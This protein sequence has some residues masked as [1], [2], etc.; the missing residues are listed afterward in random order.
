M[1]SDYEF[2]QTDTTALVNALIAAYE[3][4]TGIT[5][6]PASPERLFIAQGLEVVKAWSEYIGIKTGRVES[7]T[8]ATNYG[9]TTEWGM[10]YD[11]LKFLSQFTGLPVSNLAREGESAYNTAAT[12]YNDLYGTA[13]GKKLPML[14]AWKGAS[15]SSIERAYKA[16]YLTRDEAT[17]E[18]LETLKKSNGGKY[19]ENDAGPT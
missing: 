5:V 6:H 16:G 2:I 17:K 8:K 9:R 15:K 10:V 4:L 12:L 14:S 7:P 18:I 13:N 11:T 3:K 19:T 1:R